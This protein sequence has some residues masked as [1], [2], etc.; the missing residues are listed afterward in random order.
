MF[1]QPHQQPPSYSD[2]PYSVTDGFSSRSSTNLTNQMGGWRPFRPFE[3]PEP[4]YDF[5][6]RNYPLPLVSNESIL[7]GAVSEQENSGTNSTTIAPQIG[8][9]SHSSQ[10]LPMMPLLPN[11]YQHAN[12]NGHPQNFDVV[13]LLNHNL[14]T[15][16]SP[17]Q[18]K[19]TGASRKA[20]AERSPNAPM[21]IRAGKGSRLPKNQLS[22]SARPFIPPHPQLQHPNIAMAL[23]QQQQLLQMRFQ[24]QLQLQYNQAMG[25]QL[26]QGG[27]Y[28]DA[29]H[30]N[31]SNN[32][33]R[34]WNQ[35]Y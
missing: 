12:H 2:Q 27:N 22:V 26:L 34:Q 14:L 10:H 16:A 1:Q 24:Q 21:S 9:Y 4:F 11:V 15:A 6:S 18:F 7:L 8:P 3:V 30:P 20:L 28:P 29:Y 33:T 35:Q 25:Q 17:F 31:H 19:S 5:P 13:P 23:Q 32:S